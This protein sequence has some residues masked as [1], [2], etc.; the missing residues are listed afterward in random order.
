MY[1]PV[2]CIYF[3]IYGWI[4]LSYSVMRSRA[5]LLS[6]CRDWLVGLCW[7][8]IYGNCLRGVI[9]SDFFRRQAPSGFGG[10]QGRFCHTIPNSIQA[11]KKKFLFS[12]P[13]PPEQRPAASPTTTTPLRRLQAIEFAASPFR[14]PTSPLFLLRLSLRIATQSP[15]KIFVFSS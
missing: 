11:T 6:S 8:V 15:G 14:R 3:G 10:A 12:L 2:L 13:L 7:L 9:A 1:R 4:V 5:S